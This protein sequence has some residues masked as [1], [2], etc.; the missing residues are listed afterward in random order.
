MQ[1][2]VLAPTPV[3]LSSRYSPPSERTFR[4]ISR[5]RIRR[6]RRPYDVLA[7]SFYRKRSR[8]RCNI[9]RRDVTACV[10]LRCEG[11]TRCPSRHSRE[12]DSHT[13][14]ARASRWAFFSQ[15]HSRHRRLPSSVFILRENKRS[16]GYEFQTLTQ[17]PVREITR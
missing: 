5:G 10:C 16:S 14:C 11:S 9:N 4:F 8:N 15:T 7:F 13:E 12:A 1:A 3:F 2:R 6:H 17:Q